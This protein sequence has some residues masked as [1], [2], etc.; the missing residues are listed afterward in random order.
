MWT[1]WILK[2]QNSVKRMLLRNEI[3]KGVFNASR[4]LGPGRT[5]TLWRC[6]ARQP[7][8]TGY[9]VY[10]FGGKIFFSSRVSKLDLLLN[11]VLWHVSCL[12]G[13]LMACCGRSPWIQFSRASGTAVNLGEWR[14][15]RLWVSSH[16]IIEKQSPV[17]V[18][19][20][21]SSSRCGDT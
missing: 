16:L 14:P 11:T 3:E 6:R 17:E 18:P 20:E 10:A 1:I 8:M 15:N 5:A 9:F 7:W 12:P 21:A 4:R 19:W 2:V 13:H